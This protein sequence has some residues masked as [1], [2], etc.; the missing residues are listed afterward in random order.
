[1][2]LSLTLFGNLRRY[3]E[4][5]LLLHRRKVQRNINRQGAIPFGA[6]DSDD[7]DDGDEHCQRQRWYLMGGPAGLLNHSWRFDE[8]S[9]NGSTFYVEI[10][11]KFKAGEEITV[12]YGDAYWKWV[13]GRF[14]IS[15]HC[16]SCH[17]E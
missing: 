9:G 3:T 8:R 1:V 15:C 10:V 13:E 2:H 6:N 16:D 5:K 4:K 17:S 7:D 12:H 11:C 14:G